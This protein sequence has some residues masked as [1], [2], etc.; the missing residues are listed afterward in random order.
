MGY[1]FIVDGSIVDADQ[2]PCYMRY[3]PSLKLLLECDAESAH[4]IASRHGDRLWHIKG[5][6]F[7]S[8]DD[9]T[10][11][12][13]VSAEDDEINALVDAFVAKCAPIMV[14]VQ[15]L[16]SVVADEPSDDAIEII[17]ERIL[18]KMAAECENRIKS[19]FD[20]CLSDGQYHHFSM[21]VTDYMNLLS[22]EK[23]S[24]LYGDEIPYQPENEELQFYS[25][26]DF[27]AI[28]LGASAHRA[29]NYVYL[30]QLNAYVNSLETIKDLQA[31]FY[32]IDLPNRATRKQ[33]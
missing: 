32:G 8:L 4:F 11:V 12:D 29:E 33:V 7:E 23:M 24:Y 15:P 9:C 2:S 16:E 27:S 19:G 6:D 17:K 20:I 10:S 5:K 13:V 18:H 1:K 22:M 31:V 25:A 28:V 30:K 3:N 21:D 26:E 14:E